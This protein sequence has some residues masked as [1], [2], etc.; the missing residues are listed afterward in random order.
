MRQTIRIESRGIR[1]QTVALMAV[2]LEPALF[3]EFVATKGMTSF[4]YLLN[5][6]VSSD[7]AADL[8]C[9]DLYKT[10]DIEELEAISGTVRVL[11][12]DPLE[13]TAAP[14]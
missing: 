5:L 7:D 8:F 9:L 13:L 10:I 3:S 4:G 12:R 11:R 1:S 6:P 2:A 14:K